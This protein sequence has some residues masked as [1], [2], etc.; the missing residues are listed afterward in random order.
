M[1]YK[2]ILSKIFTIV[3]LRNG[4]GDLKVN[5]VFSNNF[6]GFFIGKNR[7]NIVL[8]EVPCLQDNFSHIEDLVFLLFH[9]IMHFLVDQ[10]ELIGFEVNKLNFLY[11]VDKKLKKYNLRAESFSKEILIR[12]FVPRGYFSKYKINNNDFL[13]NKK[14]NTKEKLNLQ[15]ISTKILLKLYK[16]ID[17]RVKRNKKINIDLLN[18]IFIELVKLI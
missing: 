3:G 9:E 13:L 11:N 16:E 14:A 7:G 18:M 5:F 17:E 4:K 2:R 12:L 6:T 15:Y 1:K 8:I 10:Q